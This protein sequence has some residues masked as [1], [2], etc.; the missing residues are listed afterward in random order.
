MP[1][2]RYWVRALFSE[3]RV[4]F[5]PGAQTV[6][7]EGVEFRDPAPYN[8]PTQTSRYVEHYGQV[9]VTDGKLT[10][11]SPM[12]QIGENLQTGEPIFGALNS[13]LAA[14]QVHEANVPD[15]AI[16]FQSPT[17]L[18][19]FGMMQDVGK[20]FGDR[21]NG[22][23]YGWV[24]DFGSPIS[25]ESGMRWRNTNISVP[26]LPADPRW[27]TLSHMTG[28]R[29]EIELPNGEYSV[30]AILGE[31]DVGSTSTNM[32]DIEGISF[33]DPDL[34]QNWRG[35]ADL[36]MTRV[37]VTDGRLT[38]DDLGTG[39]KLMYVEIT[40]VGG[41]AVPEPATLALLGLLLGAAV[42]RRNR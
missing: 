37:N 21:G 40:A 1:D 26:G 13:K 42:L 24:D 12:F 39:C 19:M 7:I 18:D 8:A 14:V 23:T 38:L 6:Q 4:D 10:I 36:Y 33:N 27:A 17:G 9:E 34:N 15:I 25:V 2:G 30:I 16:N 32:L 11:N 28:H 29:W 31:P 35:E 20:P 22:Y 3:P 5:T 41:T